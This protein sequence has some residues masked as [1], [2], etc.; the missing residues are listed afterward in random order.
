MLF[1]PENVKRMIYFLYSFHQR[2]S[3]GS[4]SRFIIQ[5][6]SLRINLLEL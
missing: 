2:E 4:E 3:L 6:P 5:L 1:F